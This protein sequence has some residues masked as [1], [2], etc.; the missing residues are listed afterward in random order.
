[1]TAFRLAIAAVLSLVTLVAFSTMAAEQKKCAAADQQS[2]LPLCNAPEGC[3][4]CLGVGGCRA[5]ETQTA[6][7][8]FN[9]EP[10]GA[11][12]VCWWQM[13][14]VNCDRTCQCITR[15][16]PCGNDSACG[17]GSQNCSAWNT[18]NHVWVVSTS[19]ECNSSDDC[20]AN[21]P[22]T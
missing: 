16:H 2:G 11:A 17:E 20:P 22:P 1:M 18:M 4:K 12:E 21:P 9:A 15:Y 14:D 19:T 8:I 3:K 13:S 7:P 10:Q 5:N 6:G